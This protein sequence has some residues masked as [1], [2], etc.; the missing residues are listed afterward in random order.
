MTTA[1][2]SGAAAV[3]AGTMTEPVCRS[4]WTRHSRRVW[5]A[6]RIESIAAFSS[7]SDRSEAACGAS[8]S[9]QRLVGSSGSRGLVK[10]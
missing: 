5:N 8:A 6:E 4:P 10:T 9:E 2:A 1:G 3:A 7:A